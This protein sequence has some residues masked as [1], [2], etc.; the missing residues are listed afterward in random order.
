MSIL[1]RR[2]F[3]TISTQ[4]HDELKNAC[5]IFVITNCNICN[6][7]NLLVKMPL[8]DY[9]WTGCYHLLESSCV[10]FAI[11]DANG[12]SFWYACSSLLQCYRTPRLTATRPLLHQIPPYPLARGMQGNAPPVAP[13][14]S[15]K[16]SRCCFPIVPLFCWQYI[17][18]TAAHYTFMSPKP[19]PFR[20]IR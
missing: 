9:C 19:S 1:K 8:F 6:W 7:I 14:I 12:I 2:P 13:N 17:I 16:I 20:C 5:T 4:Y 3:A 10:L 15:A 18:K 11:L